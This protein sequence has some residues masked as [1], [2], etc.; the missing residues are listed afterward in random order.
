MAQ[1]QTEQIISIIEQ[2]LNLGN[3]AGAYSLQ[4]AATINNA[5]TVLKTS[6][7]INVPITGPVETEVTE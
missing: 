2:A 1:T 6:L 4:D 3:K 7:G 5:F